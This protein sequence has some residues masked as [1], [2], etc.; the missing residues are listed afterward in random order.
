MWQCGAGAAEGLPDGGGERHLH[1]GARGVRPG[2]VTAGELTQAAQVSACMH[3][4]T[5]TSPALGTR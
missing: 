1:A 2:M 5:G 4:C 3:R